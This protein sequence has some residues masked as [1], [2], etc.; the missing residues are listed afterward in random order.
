MDENLL[1]T[2]EILTLNGDLVFARVARG[3]HVIK[4]ASNQ[5]YL[6]VDDRQLRVLYYFSTAKTLP[7]AFEEMIRDR[8]CPTLQELYE[9]ILKAYACGVLRSA[10]SKE[11]RTA[12]VRWFFEI[13]H[14]LVMTFSV[15]CLLAA[16]G[17]L[18]WFGVPLP[19]S[20]EQ[21]AAAWVFSCVL[22]S[23]GFVVSACVLRKA[24]GEIYRPVFHWRT[25][26]PGFRLDLR[27]SLLASNSVQAGI[28]LGLVAPV[29]LL[30]AVLL[31][32][33]PSLAFVPVLV[34]L[35]LLRPL[36]GGLITRLA[37]ILRK[38]RLLS[39]EHAFLFHFNR[40]P[41]YRIKR[42]W[43]S[44][45]WGSLVFE[46][47]GAVLWV[48]FVARVAYFGVGQPLTLLWEAGSDYW[49]AMVKWILVGLL[50][51]WCA[52]F[53]FLLLSRLVATAKSTHWR[54][55]RRLGRLW[56]KSAQTGRV[57]APGVL[58]RENWLLRRLDYSAQQELAK[59][60][61]PLHLKMWQTIVEADEPSS[62]VGIIGSGS[63]TA[64]RR[65]KSGRRTK[66]LLLRE[67]D[68][69]GAHALI[70]PFNTRLELRTNSPV[71]AFTLTSAQFR[72]L[73]LAR[74]GTKAVYEA[75]QKQVFLRRLDL[76]LGWKPHVI[77]RFAQLAQVVQYKAGELIVRQ[78]GE[79]RAFHVLFE[80][81]ARVMHGLQ[82]IGRILPGDYIGEIGLLQNSDAT[83]DVEVEEDS[84]C[85]VVNKVDFL[86]FITHNH[87]VALQLERIASSRLGRPIYPMDSFSFETH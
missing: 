15:V 71:H 19:T 7:A 30:V 58:I 78:G 62:L 2:A 87:G 44:L 43:M 20:I 75:T 39:S 46:F 83:A 47:V 12:A 86:R 61:K 82:R 56:F 77:A 59:Q 49:F 35:Y 79:T 36:R 84:L 22:L 27:D 25:L 81:S 50:G 14:G 26:L 76:C 63:M 1:F 21:V 48:L 23:A 34:L 13:S 11:K 53:L 68:V 74:L 42:E 18:L 80:G 3:Q 6:T 17:E 85:L 45:E 69:F 10:K 41:V 60:M 32:W 57:H 54:W 31:I 73:V 40:A 37:S 52:F 5:G 72:D 16:M 66:F 8:T 64:F 28:E 51:S 4:N 65:N 29:A 9:L 70:D 67:G 38:Q 55:S 33:W 24:G